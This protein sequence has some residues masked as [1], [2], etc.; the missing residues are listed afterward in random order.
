M[1]GNDTI[2]I[3]G[4]AETYTIASSIA[5]ITIKSASGAHIRIPAFGTTGG[6]QIRFDDGEGHLATDD[7]GNTF[8]LSGNA[9]VQ[10]IGS[11]AVSINSAIMTFA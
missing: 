11:V 3:L 9:G 4:S 5:G 6:L 2:V 10:D 7:G 1:R 8:H